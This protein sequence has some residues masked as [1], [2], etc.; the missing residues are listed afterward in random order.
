MIYKSLI[1]T[2]IYLACTFLL[3]SQN[4]GKSEFW[5]NTGITSEL[6]SVNA[7]NVGSFENR[8][9]VGAS[10][11]IEKRSYLN[12]N[13]NIN[14]GIQVKSFRKS[15]VF[16]PIEVFIEDIHLFI[17]VL[18]NYHLKMHEN[19]YGNFLMGL[20]GV[21]HTLGEASYSSMDYQVHIERKTGIF[22][23]LVTGF[24][25]KFNKK[26]SF[27]INVLYNMGFFQRKVEEVKYLPADTNVRLKNNGSFFELEFKYRL[28]KG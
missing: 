10:F 5:V 14:Y 23:N 6:L 1:L 7:T 16:N 18:L 27:E 24:G 9:R 21:L 25:Y 12:E 3:Y 15:F 26:R 20:N 11:G 13:F 28:S 19:H 22:P 4:R 2:L 8:N 17:P